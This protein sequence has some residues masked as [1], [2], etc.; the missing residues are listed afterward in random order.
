MSDLF[1]DSHPASI[2][3]AKTTKSSLSNDTTK[4]SIA[5]TRF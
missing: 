1:L 3:N 4:G 5:Q 2:Y